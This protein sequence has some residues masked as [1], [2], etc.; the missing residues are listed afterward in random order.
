MY[1]HVSC[2]VAP[3]FKRKRTVRTR[4]RPFIRVGALMLRHVAPVR[5]RVGAVVAREQ[6]TEGTVRVLHT[7]PKIFRPV[8]SMDPRGK[9]NSAVVVSITN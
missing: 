4:V 8:Q 5:A 7:L 9:Q 1:P 6:W 2:Q 3:I